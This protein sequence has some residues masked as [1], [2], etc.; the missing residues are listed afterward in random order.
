MQI[1]FSSSADNSYLYWQKTNPTVFKHIN[2]L[3]KAI[4]KNPYQGI[5][6]PAPL[7]QSLLGYYSRRI[8]LEHR[9]VYKIRDKT[10]FIAQ[11]Q[12]HY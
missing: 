1:I 5:G 12:Y 11:L 6:K 7:Q 4:Q 8:S 2:T 10:L 3:I 9:I